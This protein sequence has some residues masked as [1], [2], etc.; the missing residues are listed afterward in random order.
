[1]MAR[2]EACHDVELVTVSITL[3]GAMLLGVRLV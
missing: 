3:F 2:K 1:M